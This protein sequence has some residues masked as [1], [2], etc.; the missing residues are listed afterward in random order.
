MS[1]PRFPLINGSEPGYSNINLNLLGS[2]VVG[3]SGIKYEM[4]QE[5]ENEYALGEL[6][7]SRSYGVKEPSGSITLLGSAVEALRES[8]SNGDLT[9]IPPFDIP[10]IWTP[11]NSVEIH[12]HI[13]KACEFTGDSVDI[14]SKD[15]KYE[16]ELGLVIG[17][18]DYNG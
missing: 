1:R 3:I 8:V 17:D 11:K 18:I 5:K 6:P 16:T 2:T 9:D 4:K 10:V 7:V 14:K 15:K 13:L 12:T